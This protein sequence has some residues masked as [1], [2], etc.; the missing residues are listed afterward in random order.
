MPAEE[1][2]KC[3]KRITKA[4]CSVVGKKM[5][6]K[7]MNPAEGSK[8]KRTRKL[9]GSVVLSGRDSRIKLADESA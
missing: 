7:H 3:T 8:S 6:S 4:L 2:K 5:Q 9:V 1:E